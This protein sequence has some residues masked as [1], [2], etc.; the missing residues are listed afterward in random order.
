MLNN[1]V[2]RAKSTECYTKTVVLGHTAEY[3][4]PITAR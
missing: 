4:R 2:E 1:D 3:N